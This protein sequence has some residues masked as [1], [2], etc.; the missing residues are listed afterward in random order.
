MRRQAEFFVGL[1]QGGRQEIGVAGLLATARERDL[2]FVVLNGVCPLRQEQV[3]RAI[4]FE[5]RHEHSG[6][7]VRM[8]RQV[9]RRRRPEPLPPSEQETHSMHVGYGPP[10]LLPGLP[11]PLPYEI[12]GGAVRPATRSWI[13]SRSSWPGAE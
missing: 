8:R 10:A 9:A 2:P 6:P 13:S 5:E 1:A 3:R 4:G 7:A 12:W 11:F